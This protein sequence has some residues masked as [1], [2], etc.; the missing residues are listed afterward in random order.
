ME[1]DINSVANAMDNEISVYAFAMCMLAERYSK[2]SQLWALQMIVVSCGCRK[3]GSDTRVLL[4]IV[5][6]AAATT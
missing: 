3:C 5:G 4:A 1:Q 6:L 2:V